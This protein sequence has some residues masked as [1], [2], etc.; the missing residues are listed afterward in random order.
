MS[1]KYV[2]M[3]TQTVV[4]LLIYLYRCTK[5]GSKS[6]LSYLLFSKIHNRLN[7]GGSRNILQLA[8]AANLKK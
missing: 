3:C 5:M 6:L 4:Y 7:P 8:R 2:Y 1:K